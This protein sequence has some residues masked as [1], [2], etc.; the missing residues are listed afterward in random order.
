MKDH[1]YHFTK[2]LYIFAPFPTFSSLKKNIHCSFIKYLIIRQVQVS[3]QDYQNELLL[4]ISSRTPEDLPNRPAKHLPDSISLAFQSRLPV[5]GLGGPGSLPRRLVPSAWVQLLVH[6]SCKFSAAGLHPSP[7]PT[8]KHLEKSPSSVCLK[9][10]V[11]DKEKEQICF[12]FPFK[13]FRFWGTVR[14]L[15]R[16]KAVIP[17]SF[18]KAGDQSLAEGP[19]PV[20]FYIKQNPW[21]WYT[22]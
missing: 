2:F 12:F 3:R 22:S 4:P 19:S 20:L 6:Q 5:S 21:G 9:R 14:G 16:Q 13:A 10:R 15:E 8:N 7:L 17:S 11:G 1:H 18:W